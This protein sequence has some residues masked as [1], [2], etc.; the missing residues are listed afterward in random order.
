ME[1][2]KQLEITIDYILECISQYHLGNQQDKKLLLD[3]NKAIESSMELREKKE[4]IEQFINS[5]TVSTEVSRDWRT[6]ID[7]KKLE[8]FDS[9]ISE[10]GLNKDE[11][12]RFIQN[13]F[14]DGQVQ[15]T[16]TAITKVLPPAS[17]FSP[18][19]ARSSKRESVLDRLTGFFNK[20]FDISGGKF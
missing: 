1:L 3:I 20:F 7:E 16:G 9:I 11:A 15:T 2:V 19:N 5:L 18:D 12:Y 8:E 10:E 17:R 4:L 6:F 13:S 14:R